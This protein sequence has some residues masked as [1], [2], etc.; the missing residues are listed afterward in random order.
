MSSPTVR[1][2]GIGRHYVVSGATSSSYVLQ[3]GDAGKTLR[4]VVTTTNSGGFVRG[5]LDADERRRFDDDDELELSVE[6]LQRGRD[7]HPPAPNGGYPSKGRWT[8]EASGNGLTQ[9]ESREQYLVRKLN[10]DSY[11]AQ[12][13]C[14]KTY[15]PGL[16]AIVYFDETYS[17]LRW[18]LATATSSM[19]GFKSFASDPNFDIPSQVKDGA[20]PILWMSRR[21]PF[22]TCGGAPPSRTSCGRTEPLFRA[23]DDRGGRPLIGSAR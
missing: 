18:N 16:Y 6:L 14:A 8:G 3:S 11:D 20:R 17:G 5:D 10:I 9:V 1:R 2:A 21:A 15:I 7:E 12:N 23:R 4:A 13:R 19:N 22:L